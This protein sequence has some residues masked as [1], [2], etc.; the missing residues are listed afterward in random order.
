MVDTNFGMITR[1]TKTR[2]P[3]EIYTKPLTL[4]EARMVY[5]LLVGESIEDVDIAV[6]LG[7]NGISLRSKKECPVDLSKLAKEFRGGGIKMPQVFLFL[8]Y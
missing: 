8:A 7:N 3:E 1:M 6:I 2:T 4:E 5:R